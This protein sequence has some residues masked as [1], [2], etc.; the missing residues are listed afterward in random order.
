M[1][2]RAWKRFPDELIEAILT[3]PESF[4]WDLVNFVHAMAITRRIAHVVPL[5]AQ[6]AAQ[7]WF[8]REAS[9]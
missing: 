9:R 3:T 2:E 5:G 6:A 1:T 4:P 8:V 7:G